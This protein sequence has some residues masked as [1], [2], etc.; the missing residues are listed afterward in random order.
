[1][2]LG[3]CGSRGGNRQQ[4]HWEGKEQREGASKVAGSLSVEGEQ[5]ESQKELEE[6]DKQ[7][8]KCNG[9]LHGVVR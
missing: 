8:G 5:P 1:M 9:E 4:G 6:K 3:R 2:D 7:R